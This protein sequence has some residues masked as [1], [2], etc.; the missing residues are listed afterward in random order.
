MMGAEQEEAVETKK[1][2]VEIG[3]RYCG[4]CNAV[5][6]REKAVEDLKKLLPEVSFVKA[7]RGTRYAA[8]LIVNGCDLACTSVLDLAV[9]KDRQVWIESPEELE[10]ARDRIL[11]LL[12]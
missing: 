10:A 1:H 9:P 5:Y 4:G 8:A 12:A 6:D 7:E 2:P 11:E 3:V